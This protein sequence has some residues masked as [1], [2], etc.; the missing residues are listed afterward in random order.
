MHIIPWKCIT[1]TADNQSTL[2]PLH[3]RYFTLF[4]MKIIR[5]CMYQKMILRST[6]FSMELLTAVGGG[7]Y[8]LVL[9]AKVRS[10]LNSEPA[11]K[12]K[13]MY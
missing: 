1:C 10:H 11:T 6:V 3:G 4:C 5:T 8:P 7:G 13:I 9:L 12:F 2:A